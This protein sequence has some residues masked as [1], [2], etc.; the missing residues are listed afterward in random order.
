MKKFV[1]SNRNVLSFRGAAITNDQQFDAKRV[2]YKMAN[3]NL[4]LEILP[5]DLT[6]RQ[7]ESSAR[8]S[9]LRRFQEV[10]QGTET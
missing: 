9:N 8:E 1:V 2:G 7:H 3:I 6:T 4:D 10:I 5:G